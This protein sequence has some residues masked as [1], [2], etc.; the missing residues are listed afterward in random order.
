MEVNEFAFSN[1]FLDTSFLALLI[2]LERSHDSIFKHDEA[3][4]V[5]SNL[6]VVMDGYVHPC[7]R[8]NV[9]TTRDGRIRVVNESNRFHERE[10]VAAQP[11]FLHDSFL[12]S[13]DSHI[14]EY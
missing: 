12:T 1:I 11:D 14:Y 8:T 13:V 7:V 4:Y 10:I 6:F 2:I 3:A 9:F 5:N